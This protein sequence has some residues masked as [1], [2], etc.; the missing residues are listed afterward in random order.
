MPKID[1]TTLA[2]TGLMTSNLG[3]KGP[4]RVLCAVSAGPDSPRTIAIGSRAVVVGCGS[5]CDLP[6]TDSHVSRRHLEIRIVDQGIQVRDLNSTNGSFYQGSRI[7]ELV[8]PSGASIQLGSTTLSLGADDRPTVPPSTRTRFGDLVGS[9]PIMREIFAI[10]ELASPTEAT[11]L[12]EGESGTGKELVARAIHEHSGRANGPLVVVDCSSLAEGLVDSHLFGHL[13]G[14]FTGAAGD[15]QGAFREAAGGTVFLDEIGELP[16][17]VQAKLL[18]ALEDDSVQPVGSDKRVSTDARVVAATHRDLNAMVA[19][20][21]FRF[22]LFHRLAVVQIRMPPLRERPGDIP[23][24]VHK[25]YEG[26][27]FDPGPILGE[28]LDRLSAHAWPGNVRELRNVLERAWVLSPPGARL[29]QNMR[30]W[31]GK[32]QATAGNSVI[33]DSLP[34]KEAKARVVADFERRYLASVYV[35]FGNNLT[36][37]AAHAGIDRGHFRELLQRHELY[38]A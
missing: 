27:R 4:R 34:F 6:L 12:I 30:F 25:F 19:R 24:L 8:V 33:D 26:H 5:D 23:E 28:N 9:S 38:E 1:S 10:L 29:F 37:A 15:R 31:L 18:R 11:V 14:A 3:S 17:A 2:Q 7:T 36:K 20:G 21:D 32:E 13:R 35:K 16:L 22:D